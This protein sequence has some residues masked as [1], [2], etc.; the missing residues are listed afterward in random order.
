MTHLLKKVTVIKHKGLGVLDLKDQSCKRIYPQGLPNHE[1]VFTNHDH[2]P[3]QIRCLIIDRLLACLFIVVSLFLLMNVTSVYAADP[4]SKVHA[5]LDNSDQC[6]QCHGDDINVAESSKCRDCHRDIDRRIRNAQG[7]HGRI[8][9][10]VNCNFCH[11]EHLGRNYQ[12]VQLDTQNFD[13]RQTGW[14]LDGKHAQTDCRSCH[15]EQ[16]KSGRDSYLNTSPECVSCHSMFHGRGA[17][18]P[19]DQ[20]Q[21]CH[22]AFGWQQMNARIKFDHQTKTRYPLTGAHKKSECTSCHTQRNDKGQIKQ[23][24]PIPVNGC[25]SCHQDPHPRGIFSGFSCADCHVTQSFKK[26]SQFNHRKTGWP[27]KGAHTR[28]DCLECHS[29]RQWKPPSS[30][31]VECHED[32]HDGQFVGS[33]CQDCHSQ[34]S[35]SKIHFNHDTQSQFPLEGKH[36]RVQCQK[37]HPN[38]QY[39]PL[40]MECED[41]HQDKNPHGDTFGDASCAKCHSPKGWF[42][43]HFDHS[44]TGFALEGR[45]QDQP[46]YRCHP[47][48]T[49]LEDDTQ[50]ECAFCH[51]PTIHRSQFPQQDCG[52]CHKGSYSWAISFFDHSQ[53]RFELRGKHL[54]VA[55][56]ACH[57]DGHFKPIDTA[58]ANC[59]QNFHE[60]QINQECDQCHT[61]TQWDLVPFDHNLQSQYP[62]EGLHQLVDCKQ[63]HLN[64][65]YK[66]LNQDCAS[67]HL[68]VHEGK[69][70]PDC[71]QCHTLEGWDSNQ[72]INH[73]FGAFKLGGIHDQL[74][75][76]SCHGPQ[77]EKSLSGTGPECVSC[78]RDP[79]FGSLGPLCLDCHTQNYF[80]PS[81]FLH[82]S[83]GFRLSGAHRFVACRDCHP[84]RVYGGLPR[85]CSFCHT[86][87]FQS[88]SAGTCDHPANCPDALGR[89]QECHTSTSFQIARPG[90]QC[91]IS[92]AAGGQR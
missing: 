6:G 14:S 66:G 67:C 81:T 71:A 41:C 52:E 18:A 77:R 8:R 36:Q 3:H 20:C 49:E 84:G 7:Y 65:Q 79:H 55:C 29:W 9:G 86:D 87:T 91:G 50:P 88:T 47:N 2:I 70:G 33:S 51:T 68:D 40:P 80:L 60:G 11:R 31:C 4:L 16:R 62:L 63:C 64:N 39:K 27:L 59:H 10:E 24:G 54:S 72:A 32:V 74:P 21:E 15:T 23:F 90:S 25:E 37:C 82:N 17:V 56:D 75:C 35:F 34:Q 42:E 73:N 85:D 57:K 53:S 61:A 19:L 30:E 28:Q 89:C 44:I 92:C 78:H 26:T 46:C 22:N 1:I 43:T 48:G 58:C 12:I 45:H 76:E 5:H 38:G 13:H 69:K 83:T